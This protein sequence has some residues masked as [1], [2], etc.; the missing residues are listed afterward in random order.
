M[1]NDLIFDI[2]MH[3]GT[4]TAFYVSKGFRVVAVEANPDLVEN[5]RR[6]F[7]AEIAAGQVTVLHRALDANSG[8]EITLYIAA[9]RTDVSSVSQQ[10]VKLHADET[11][12]AVQVPCVTLDELIRS[13]GTPYYAKIDIEGHDTV[14]LPALLRAPAP[15]RFLS[16][17]AK[18][19]SLDSC[20]ETFDLLMQ[21][22]YRRFKVVNQRLNRKIELPNPAR[23]GRYVDHR[24]SGYNSGPFGEETPGPW[25]DVP[26]ALKRCKDV[27][28][29]CDNFGAGG[30]F[31]GTPIAFCYNT[32]RYLV[33][34]DR[35]GWYDI[36]A[37]L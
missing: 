15:P 16:V 17:E 21:A 20:T 4:D 3:D 34:R 27:K 7:A 26:G 22:G 10:P 30:T 24:F 14:C 8:G 29:L 18:I 23:E 35:P 2:G 12:T 9:H 6:T 31:D 25:M 19:Q 36:H 32:Y 1:Q 33:H 28:W 5:A 37:S 13:Y 11:F